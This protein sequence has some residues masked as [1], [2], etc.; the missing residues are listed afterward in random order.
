MYG[1]FNTRA[2][3][4]VS[5]ILYSNKSFIVLQDL[6]SFKPY[7]QELTAVIYI[8]ID[9]LELVPGLLKRLQIRPHP[10]YCSFCFVLCPSVSVTY[11]FLI[12]LIYRS[13]VSLLGIVRR[14]TDW[15]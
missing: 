6:T 3:T 12:K 2:F 4:V 7:H 8:G 14:H 13:K 1:L 9:S 11:L 10:T 5:I 15:Y